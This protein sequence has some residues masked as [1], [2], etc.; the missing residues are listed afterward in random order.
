MT[1]EDQTQAV[2]PALTVAPLDGLPDDFTL[3]AL[4]GTLTEAEIEALKGGD[5]PVLVEPVAPA[6]EP[7]A[8]ASE[9]EPVPEV[10]VPDTREAEAVVQQMEAEIAKLAEAYDDGDLTRDEW[11]TQQRTLIAQ[12]AAAQAQIA[13]AQQVIQQQSNAIA[14]RWFAELDAYHATNPELNTPDV[15]PMWDAALKSV[16]SNAAYQA[17]PNATRMNL[18]HQMLNAHL[19]ATTGKGLSSSPA[20]PAAMPQPQPQELQART[21]PRPEAPITLAGMSAVAE[22]SPDDGTFAAIDRMYSTDPLK[23]EA[24]LSRLSAEQQDAFLN[25]R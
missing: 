5:D 3:D 13:Q 6:P 17:L 10:Q 20:A 1:T 8:P 11:L 22:N 19:I 25:G 23:A 24:M 2:E 14:E 18:A 16:N 4:T 21:D 12:Q 7:V 15:L 9:P